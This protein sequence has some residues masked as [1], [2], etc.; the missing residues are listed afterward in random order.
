M[1]KIDALS[2]AVEL[3]DQTSDP[4]AEKNI[5]RKSWSYEVCA[6]NYI[7]TCKLTSQIVEFVVTIFSCVCLCKGI[8]ELMELL[9]IHVEQVLD[10]FHWSIDDTQLEQ[11]ANIKHGVSISKTI[12][13]YPIAFSTGLDEITHLEITVDTVSVLGYGFCE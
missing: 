9:Q 8:P 4:H 1:M 6:D 7:Q 5:L 3:P 11:M 13:V 12:K 2:T 10:T